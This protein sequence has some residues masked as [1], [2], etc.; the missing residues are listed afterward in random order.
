[1]GKLADILFEAG[2]GKDNAM[3]V[4][5]VLVSFPGVDKAFLKVH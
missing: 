4:V 2:H 5:Y 1:M 3:M